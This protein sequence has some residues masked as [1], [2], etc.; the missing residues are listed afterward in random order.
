MRWLM[1]VL[2]TCVLAQSVSLV[3]PD[4]MPARLVEWK[5][6]PANLYVVTS[7]QMA[8]RLNVWLEGPVS[9]SAPFTEHPVMVVADTTVRSLGDLIAECF[10]TAELFLRRNQLP[11]GRYRL[12]VVGTDPTDSSRMLTKIACHSFV[13]GALP[14]VEAVVPRSVLRADSLVALR[15]V[16]RSKVV[17]STPS[18]LRVRVVER[19]LG[20]SAWHALMLN[21]PVATC[22]GIS[23]DGLRWECTVNGVKFERSRAYVWGVFALERQT[24]WEL[25]SEPVEFVVE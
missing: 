4:T 5:T 15:F 24:R 2:P 22:D 17:A 23:S 13:V 19:Q 6:V 14:S 12:C 21:A 11:H 1:S 7:T 20:Q 3:M 16:W 18:H 25:V 9:L 8:L 10:A